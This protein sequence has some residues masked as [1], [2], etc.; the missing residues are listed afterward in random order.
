[1]TLFQII[2]TIITLIATIII[3]LKTP[4]NSTLSLCAIV[5]FS[6]CWLFLTCCHNGF[7]IFYVWIALLF[8][9]IL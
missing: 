4:I 2:L 8:L 3:F 1:M 7:I 6:T 5:W 9:F